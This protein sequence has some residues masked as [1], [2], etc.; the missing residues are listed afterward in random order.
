MVRR[1]PRST[2]FPYTT[3]FR[4]RFLSRFAKT[5]LGII[6]FRGTRL[7]HHTYTFKQTASF[8]Q[9]APETWCQSRVCGA[10]LTLWVRR[11]RRCATNAFR[12]QT[13]QE[14]C[15][16]MKRVLLFLV[17]ACTM[18]G[19][20]AVRPL[21]LRSEYR[22]NPQGIDVTEPRLS[23]V[24]TPVDPHA[25][26]LRQSAYRVLV[27]SSEAALHANTGDLW[28]S[29]KTVSSDSIHIVYRGK[30]LNS[31]MAAWWKVQV[32]DQNGQASDWSPDA[33]WSM[34]LLRAEDWQGKWIGRDEAGVY[35]DPGSVYQPLVHAKWIWDIDGA[36]TKAP[37]GDRYFRATFTVPA[38]RKVKRAIAVIGAD[39]RC[40]VY[41][42]GE[43]VA[44]SSDAVMPQ[45]H[46]VTALVHPG[47][48]LIAAEASHPRADTP[49]GL[50]GAVKI[51]FESGDPLLIQSG[52]Q[53]RAAAKI[54]PRSAEH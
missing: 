34:G 52:N 20:A 44:E 24:L 26:G 17:V 49:A 43:K 53:W 22:V 42:N 54:E 12:H 14:A 25:R 33:Q 6:P 15:P 3:L 47:E 21:Q 29:G 8:R 18:F 38:R 27:A 19:A 51:E 46:D 31:G 5:G 40:E 13:G 30:P 32:W 11:S 2:L 7:Q 41:V 36:Q 16:T 23:W 28:D 45:D 35:R 10:L 4:S 9:T 50:I 48:N 1:P 37:A 39:L